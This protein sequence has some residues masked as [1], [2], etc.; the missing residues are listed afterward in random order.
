[1]GFYFL[2][3]FKLFFQED[4]DWIDRIENDDKQVINGMRFN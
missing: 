2:S 3:V 1:M 4:F